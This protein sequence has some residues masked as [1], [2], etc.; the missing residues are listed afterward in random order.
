MG[1]EIPATIF[2]KKISVIIPLFTGDVG[3]KPKKSSGGKKRLAKPPS[4]PAYRF[5]QDQNEKIQEFFAN[6]LVPGGPKCSP[7]EAREFLAKYPDK[8]TDRNY[9]Q[10]QEKVIP[11]FFSM[12]ALYMYIIKDLHKICLYIGLIIG[13]QNTYFENSFKSHETREL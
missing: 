4:K 6:H 5:N 2:T 9:R 11:R 13:F 1:F 8:F 3:S 10:I 7:D 12:K